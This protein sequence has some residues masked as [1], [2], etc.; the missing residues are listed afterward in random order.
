MTDDHL[1]VHLVVA[2]GDEFWERGADPRHWEMFHHRHWEMVH[3]RHWE[4]AVHRCTEITAVTVTLT[5]KDETMGVAAEAEWETLTDAKTVYVL[6]FW[7]RQFK[8]SR[9]VTLYY[10]LDSLFLLAKLL[11]H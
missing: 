8:F 1:S 3:H 11:C 10:T 5:E 4:E 7:F 9:N 2:D 6:G